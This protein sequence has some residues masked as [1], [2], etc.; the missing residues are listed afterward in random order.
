MLK[1]FSFLGL[2]LFLLAD[3]STCSKDEGD[4]FQQINYH[5][6]GPYPVGNLT[7][8]LSVSGQDRD[9]PVEIWY[10]ANRAG[11]GQRLE[12]FALSASEHLQIMSMLESAPQ[13]CTNRE[14]QSSQAPE[15]AMDLLNLPLVVFSHCSECT[16][17]CV[18]G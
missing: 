5:K 10:P 18:A 14:T 6:P 17:G 9:L 4:E 1:A 15:P 11:E 8:T 16:P 2:S 3:L 12:D 13:S 7:V